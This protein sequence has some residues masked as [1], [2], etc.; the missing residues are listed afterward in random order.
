MNLSRQ[1]RERGFTLIELLVSMGVGLS[2][3]AAVT[4]T[5]ISLSRTYNAQQQLNEMQQNARA[6][7]D[8]ITREVKM[9]GYDPTGE[10][11]DG[12]PY[13]SSQLQIRADLNGDGDI[14]DGKEDITYTF[15]GSPDF[16]ILRNSGTNEVLAE[17]IQAFTFNYLDSAGNATTTSADIR[18]VQIAIT[19]ITRGPDPNYSSNGGFRTYQLSSSVTPPNLGYE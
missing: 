15:A 7:M 14:N 2:I 16:R 17:N 5:S 4:T 8:L 12:I 3:L 11:F 13:D 9:A 6:A 19:A 18:Q 1:N 10:S